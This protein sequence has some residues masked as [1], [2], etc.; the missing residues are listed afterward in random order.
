MTALLA[1]KPKISLVINFLRGHWSAVQR[2]FV[3]GSNKMANFR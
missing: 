3:K 1:E 2:L